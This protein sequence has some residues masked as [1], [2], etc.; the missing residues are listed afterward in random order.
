MR[1][2]VV[3]MSFRA[4]SIVS[5][6][7]LSVRRPSSLARPKAFTSWDIRSS[8]VS[9]AQVSVSPREESKSLFCCFQRSR[10]GWGGQSERSISTECSLIARRGAPEVVPPCTG[11]QGGP[12]AGRQRMSRQSRV[13]QDG[14]ESGRY[15]PLEKYVQT[16]ASSPRLP[17]PRPRKP[18]GSC[19]IACILVLPLS[20]LGV[21]LQKTVA[22]M[23]AQCRADMP[24]SRSRQEAKVDDTYQLQL[25]VLPQRQHRP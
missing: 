24:R 6:D 9:M 3:L 8:C 16:L 22:D 20:A 21:M 13:C 1:Y 19:G 5:A 4:V 10:A 2:V 18:S 25:R 7:H 23:L 14:R 15:P 11:Y 12:Y 17:D